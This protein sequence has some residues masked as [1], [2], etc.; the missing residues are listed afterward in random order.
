HYN[1]EVNN[2]WQEGG[3]I[4]SIKLNLGYRFVLS[5]SKFP[6]H[7][8]RG[9]RFAFSIRLINRGFSSPYN[10]RPVLLVFRNMDNGF[11]YQQAIETQIQRWHPGDIQLEQQVLLPKNLERGKYEVLI[12]MPDQY[13]SIAGNPDYSIRLANDGTWEED[14]GYNKLNQV[15]EV[16]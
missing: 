5:Q 10:S 16:I 15:I 14:T 12:N 11:L 1:N 9:E 13:E 2:D 6:Q 8:K 4:D 7:V 3:C